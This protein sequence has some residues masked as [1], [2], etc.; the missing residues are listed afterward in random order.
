MPTQSF[1]PIQ[2]PNSIIPTHFKNARK[3]PPTKYS[4][5]SLEFLSILFIEQ[6]QRLKDDFISIVEVLSCHLDEIKGYG[7]QIN[8]NIKVKRR[9]EF[10]PGGIAE[11]SYHISVLE[12]TFNEKI[13]KYKLDN[14]EL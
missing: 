2:I 7:N 4:N 1:Q 9:N 14:L 12:S 5:V 6:N 3:K 11:L 13:R 10:Y 8:Y